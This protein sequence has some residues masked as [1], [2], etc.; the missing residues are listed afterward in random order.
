MS[1]IIDRVAES[2]SSTWRLLSDTTNFLS[3]VKLLSS[4]DRD[5]KE[6]RDRLYRF[7]KDPDVQREIRKRIV[8]IRR[9]LR[10][11]GYDLRLGSRDIALEGFRHDDAMRDGFRRL[12]IGISEDDVI[13]LA[14]DLNHQ[15]LAGQMERRLRGAKGCRS[16]SFHYLWYRWR[17]QVLVLSGS[18]S[19][20]AQQ[21][22]MFKEYFESHKDLLLRKLSHI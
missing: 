1:T 6:M 16:L 7:R 9:S 22:E 18:A 20:T 11:R 13:S 8:E 12:V 3:R 2:V 14:G 15:D 5:L 4:Y 21:F 19:E 10:A 17:S